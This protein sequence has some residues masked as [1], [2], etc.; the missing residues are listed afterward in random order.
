MFPSLNAFI[1][2]NCCVPYGYVRVI[3]F[4]IWFWFYELYWFP[5]YVILYRFR[6]ICTINMYMDRFIA[7]SSNIRYKST[8]Y[9]AKTENFE[10]F[11][12]NF[13][14]FIFSISEEVW[15]KTNIEENCWAIFL[16]QI[17]LWLQPQHSFIFFLLKWWFRF[18]IRR[19]K[20]VLFSLHRPH[21]SNHLKN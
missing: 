17:Y 18:E 20:R 15:K 3:S 14:S 21:S 11:R 12:D 16:N 7:D 5:F 9:W 13:L 4:D 10:Y 2:C 6:D 19:Q 8:S 1:Q